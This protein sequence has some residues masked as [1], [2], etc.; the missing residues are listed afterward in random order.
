[1]LNDV[2]SVRTY[3]LLKVSGSREEE[4]KCVILDLWTGAVK[5]IEDDILSRALHERMRDEGIPFIDC[6]ETLPQ[7]PS[8]V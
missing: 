5:L 7:A 2:L 4:L 8:P 6:G 3:R 1:M